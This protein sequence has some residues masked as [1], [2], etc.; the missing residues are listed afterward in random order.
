VR[1]AVAAAKP[2]CR[3]LLAIR[4]R[5]N[6]P[7]HWGVAALRSEEACVNILAGHGMAHA[8]SVLGKT[9]DHPTSHGRRGGVVNWKTP[10][11][12]I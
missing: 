7:R 8:V 9:I 10:A 4:L 2:L 1:L 11:R 6:P 3:A 5:Y 12:T